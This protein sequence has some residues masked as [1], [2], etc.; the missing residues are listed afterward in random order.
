MSNGLGAGFFAITLLAVLVGVAALLAAIAVVAVLFD[1]QRGRVPTF[2]RYLA[3][4]L[5]AVV[6]VV[7][8]FGVL[9]LVDEAPPAAALF[10][11]VVGLPLVLVAGRARQAG[12]AWLVVGATA[13]LAWSF[14]FLAGV[15]VLFAVSVIAGASAAVATVLA[16]IAVSGGAMLAG[17]F[18]RGLL[19]PGA[20]RQ[21]DL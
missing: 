15:G 3:V 20:T 10:A 16:G 21:A 4:A 12:A 11:V 6:V 18:L 7:A 8:G 5:L 19:A 1:W 13:A 2:I 9:A 14:P 17:E